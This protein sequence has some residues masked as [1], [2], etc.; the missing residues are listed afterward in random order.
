MRL[1]NEFIPAIRVIKMY[2]WEQEFAQMI[3]TARKNE[4]DKLRNCLYLFGTNMVFF[5]TG[6]KVIVYVT[7]VFYVLFSEN[8]KFNS[9]LVY[10]TFATLNKLSFILLLYLPHF[11]LSIING[12]ISITRIDKFLLL[13][14]IERTD[15][16]FKE[17]L[18]NDKAFIKVQGLY[19]SYA[20]KNDEMDDFKKR[21][22]KI[23]KK[24]RGF[25]LDEKYISTVDKY[26]EPH[27]IKNIS[28]DVKPGEILVI[29]GSVG[30]GK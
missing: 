2:C 26:N 19:A 10:V 1:M 9:E 20:A 11:F 13:E 30:S 5:Y 6:A 4:I 14:E 27:V 3:S 29:I 22:G 15:L 21:S 25:V 23:G 28:F 16:D 12:L 18:L 24:N 8:V 17:K 7:L